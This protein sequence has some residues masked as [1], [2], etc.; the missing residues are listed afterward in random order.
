MKE[1]LKKAV[2]EAIEK[3]YRSESEVLTEIQNVLV[4]NPNND[5]ECVEEII[6]IL[7]KYGYDCGGCHDF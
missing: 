3:E 6:S 1:L 7:E 5:F 4:S 2:C